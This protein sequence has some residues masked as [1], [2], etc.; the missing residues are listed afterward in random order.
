MPAQNFSELLGLIY[1]RDSQEFGPRT[2]RVSL[3]GQI[4]ILKPK[5]YMST[6]RMQKI[7]KNSATLIKPGN[8]DI[9]KCAKNKDILPTLIFYFGN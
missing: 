5:Q 2:S 4:L 7:D 1:G 9:C 3:C 8:K 6:N